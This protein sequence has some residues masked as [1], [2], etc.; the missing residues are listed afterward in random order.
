MID[1][2]E[3]CSNI[4][5]QQNLACAPSF[6][7]TALYEFRFKSIMNKNCR[8]SP[9]FHYKVTRNLLNQTGEMG[10]SINKA[11]MSFLL[12]GTTPEKYW[13]F[14]VTKFDVEPSAFCYALAQN[15]KIKEPIRLDWHG[16]SP[17]YLL[18]RIRS[19]LN[20]KFAVCIGVQITEEPINQAS[21]DGK[22]PFSDSKSLYGH[23]VL[24]VG[25]DDNIKIKSINDEKT[26]TGAVLIQNSRGK[27]W[28]DNGFGW[29][30][31]EY[32]NLGQIQDCWTISD[33]FFI[34]LGEYGL[35]Y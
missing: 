5:S 16:I 17:F 22:I 11:M 30:P 2:R 20:N 8:M 6:A 19:F 28:G 15:F 13:P 21:E 4:K 3:Y 33:S 12:F 10:F 23:A 32:I 27:A 14:D 35:S 29:L 9:L 24:V 18:E 31:Y 25:Y 26:T 34:D 1:W 7:I